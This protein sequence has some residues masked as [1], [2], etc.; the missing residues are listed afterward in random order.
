MKLRV[1][2]SILIL[3]AFFVAACTP[4]IDTAPQKETTNPQPSTTPKEAANI[5]LQKALSGDV[6]A[7][8]NLGTLYLL[9]KCQK[10]DQAL[11]WLTIAAK[12]GN[13]QGQLNLATLYAEGLGVPQDRIKARK[14]YQQA[15]AQ[16][17]I[18]SKG[19]AEYHLALLYAQGLGAKKNMNKAVELL[20]Q[21][22]EHGDGDA[23]ELINLLKTE[24]QALLFI[25]TSLAPKMNTMTS[26]I[27]NSLSPQADSKGKQGC[28]QENNLIVVKYSIIEKKRPSITANIPK[29][30]WA[31]EW[32]LNSC[33]LSVSK[34]IEFTIE[35]N[36]RKISFTVRERT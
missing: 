16:D 22:A 13:A 31:E 36:T 12:Q 7:Q 26:D 30:I 14:L 32:T 17:D 33:S 20:K 18:A 19:L 2:I 29:T 5:L 27:L 4:K 15:A 24:K 23:K 21:S 9:C 3:F 35:D 1:F 34:I 6:A 8:A 10:L 11:I 28:T 25:G